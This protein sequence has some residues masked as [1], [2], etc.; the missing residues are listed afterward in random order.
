MVLACMG[1][2]G[3]GSM[4]VCYSVKLKNEAGVC[5]GCGRKCLGGCYV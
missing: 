5:V 1:T 2:T 4:N 3:V